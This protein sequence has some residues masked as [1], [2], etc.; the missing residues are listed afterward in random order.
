MSETIYQ[1]IN[2][3]WVYWALWI[4]YG[5]T[6]LSVVAIVVMENRNPVKSLAWVTVLILLP[7]VGLI[8][9]ILFGRS[10]K[11]KRFV[12]RSNRRRLKRHEKAKAFKAEASGLNVEG[13]QQVHLGQSLIGAPYYDGNNASIFDNGKDK[14]DALKADIRNAKKFI[15]IQYYIF[16]DDKL[17]TELA[18]L[19]IGKARQGVKVKII[20]DHVGSFKVKHRFYKRMREAGIEIYPFFKVTFPHFGTRINWRN[21]RKLCLIDGSVGYI[22]G[23]NIADRYITGGKFAMW[24]DIHLRVTGPVLRSFNHAFCWDWNFMGRPIPEDFDPAQAAAAQNGIGMQLIT[25]GPTSQW[26]NISMLFLKAIGNAKKSIYLQT[27]YFLPT[28]SLL[29]ALQ[30][31]ALAKIDVRIMIPRMSDSAVLKYS[32]DSYIKECLRAG[33]KVYFYEPGMLHSKVIIIDDDFTTVGST[34]FDFRSFEHNFEGNL[35]IYSNDF[36]TRMKEIFMRDLSDSTR[37]LPYD[38]DHRPRI[39]KVKESIMRL[40]APIL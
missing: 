28:E 12:S 10:I 40:F 1:Y 34:N 18:G 25:A 26:G 20:Y 32:S 31:A 27:P 35:F 2:M 13:A 36:N 19:L 5:L 11:N 17:G 39:A 6:I 14:F 9:Y 3:T 23:M 22:G 8:L 24:R 37:V 7:A 4:A 15:Y 38:W 30:A 16:E 29:R 33:I 21:H